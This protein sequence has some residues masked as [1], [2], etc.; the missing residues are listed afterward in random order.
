[1][2]YRCQSLL[3]QTWTACWQPLLWDKLLDMT[4]N[5]LPQ[6]SL[7][8]L[9]CDSWKCIICFKVYKQEMTIAKPDSSVTRKQNTF[10]S[11][12][13]ASLPNSIIPPLHHSP[14]VS[15]SN[16]S[17]PPSITTPLH[18][19]HRQ[20]SPSKP[21]SFLQTQQQNLVSANKFLV[22]SRSGLGKG[23]VKGNMKLLSDIPLAPQTRA[24]WKRN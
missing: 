19:S 15:F 6:I 18:N 17:L 13:T 9:N 3:V 10:A 21:L 2:W 16:V 11:S 4:C 23:K 14:T 24:F 7:Y 8:F 20:S 22:I 1:M 5:F 12:P